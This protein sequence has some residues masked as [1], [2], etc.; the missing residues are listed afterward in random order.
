MPPYARLTTDK[1]VDALRKQLASSHERIEVL[2]LALYTALDVIRE[3]IGGHWPDKLKAAFADVVIDKSPITGDDIE[4]TFQL[5]EKYGWEKI[6]MDKTIEPVAKM[7]D[8][9]AEMEKDDRPETMKAAI[10]ACADAVKVLRDE[11]VDR[12]GRHEELTREIKDAV[13]QAKRY[14]AGDRA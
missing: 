6:G 12:R 11:L 3:K 13:D 4:R 9:I 2:Q 10:Y 8:A 5:N 7:F 14:G 1:Q